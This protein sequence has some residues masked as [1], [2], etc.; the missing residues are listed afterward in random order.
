[1]TLAFTAIPKRL[2]VIFCS[3]GA[4]VSSEYRR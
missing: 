4:A 2:V 1:L 3:A